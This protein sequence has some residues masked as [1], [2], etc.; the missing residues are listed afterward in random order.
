M[1]GRD[2]REHGLVALA[3]GRE[4]GRHRDRAVAQHVDRR[5]LVGADPRALHVAAE[6]QADP[7]P[8][9]AGALPLLRP[10]VPADGLQDHLQPARVVARVVDRRAAVLEADADVVGELV[11]PDQVSPPHLRAVETE[12][13]R[14]PLEHALHHEDPVRPPGPAVGRGGHRVGEHQPPLVAVVRQPVRAGE[15][16]RRD[17]REDHAV[18]AVGARVVH[19]GRLQGEDP[20]LGVAPHAHA[21]RLATLVV[22]AD[23]VLAPVLH[24]LHGHAETVGRPRHEH[25]LG[26]ELDLD[27]EAAAHVGRHDLHL[28]EAARRRWPGRRGCPWAPGSSLDEQAL[29]V[30]VPARH[31]GARLH[32]HARAALHPEG[33]L[34]HVGGPGEGRVHVALSSPKAAPTLSGSPSGW[35]ATPGRPPR[36][37]STAAGSGS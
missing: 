32:R 36:S 23:E 13:A 16:G 21:V 33:P 9:R 12:V 7:A 8:L 10:V 25:L 28:L 19:E 24:P 34:E 31:H 11:R 20:A 35:G 3:L 4:P 2:L 6:A 22:G 30:V 5:A 26:V 18:R 29:F 1:V 27:P 17:H 15:L 37:R 14:D